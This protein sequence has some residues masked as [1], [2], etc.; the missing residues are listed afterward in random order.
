[1]I[2]RLSPP[3][4]VEYPWIKESIRYRRYLYLLNKFADE[5]DLQSKRRIKDRILLIY[6]KLSEKL[7]SLYST[8]KENIINWAKDHKLR[9]NDG[10]VYQSS[11]LDFITDDLRFQIRQADFC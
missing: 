8:E 7:P 9:A 6:D 5:T 10:T 2:R 1:M 11:E 3:D 4:W